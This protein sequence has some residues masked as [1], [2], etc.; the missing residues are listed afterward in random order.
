MRNFPGRTLD[1]LDLMNWP[2][3]LRAIEAQGIEA[4][5]KQRIAQANGDIEKLD[6]ETWEA[7]LYHDSLLAG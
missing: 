4:V 6:P 7:I 5:E 2:R 3:Y 1:E